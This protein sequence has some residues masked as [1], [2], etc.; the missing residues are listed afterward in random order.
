MILVT[1]QN[2]PE[3]LVLQ[4]AS[5]EIC[6]LIDSGVL[7]ESKSVKAHLDFHKN[8]E[9][10]CAVICYVYGFHHEENS[11][12]VFSLKKWVKA[13]KNTDKIIEAVG[14]NYPHLKQKN[15]KNDYLINKKLFKAKH[16]SKIV[17]MFVE[18]DG[19]FGFNKLLLRKN[20]KVILEKNTQI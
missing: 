6:L 20:V 14:V 7:P 18:N 16:K 12:N 17:Q 13:T 10:K 5:S 2:W 4:H 11:H 3:T 15:F 9:S 8:N 1:E 19:T